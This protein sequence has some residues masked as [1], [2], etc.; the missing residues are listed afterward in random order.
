MSDAG[1][2]V[3]VD[4]ALQDGLIEEKRGRQVFLEQFLG[5]YDVEYIRMKLATAFMA[6]N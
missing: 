2:A 3:V 1:A 6:L 5:H 4:A